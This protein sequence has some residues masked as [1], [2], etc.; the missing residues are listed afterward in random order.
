MVII[1]VT[2]ELIEEPL[3]K[4]FVKFRKIVTSYL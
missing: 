4:R 2:F 3:I 1:L